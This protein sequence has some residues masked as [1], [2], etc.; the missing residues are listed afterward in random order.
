MC[1]FLDC[2]DYVGIGQMKD[3][4]N[5]IMQCQR[6]QLAKIRRENCEA[7][8]QEPM[9]DLFEASIALLEHLAERYPAEPEPEQK[10]NED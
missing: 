3:E 6:D 5:W 2:G 9:A 7:T 1:I 10:P 4:L 8:T